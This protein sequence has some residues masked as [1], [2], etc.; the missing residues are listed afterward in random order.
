MQVAANTMLQIF[1]GE[2]EEPLFIPLGFAK[3]E[4]MKKYET[5]DPDFQAFIKFNQD[6][7]KVSAAR[8]ESSFFSPPFLL[9]ME[10]YVEI[11]PSVS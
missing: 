6:K 11:S 4:P 9:Q 3:A 1:G 7:K 2:W 5:S 10:Q 8:G